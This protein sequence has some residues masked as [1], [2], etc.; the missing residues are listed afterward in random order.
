MPF[1]IV[2]KKDPDDQSMNRRM[3]MPSIRTLTQAIAVLEKDLEEGYEEHGEGT[4]QFQWWARDKGG[5]RYTFG[6]DGVES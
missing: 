4:G 6:I 5:Q 1:T 2:R 3:L